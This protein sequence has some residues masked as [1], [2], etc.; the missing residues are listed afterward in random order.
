MNAQVILSLIAGSCLDVTNKN[1]SVDGQF[2]TRPNAIPVAFRSYRADK[3]RVAAIPPV[4]AKQVR[5][6]AVI[7]DQD[8]EI[9][10]VVEVSNGQCA[11]D[12][13]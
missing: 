3:Q 12:F 6:L 9:T 10:V 7:A 5:R 11:A 1:L 4:V 2:Q 13:L 8:I